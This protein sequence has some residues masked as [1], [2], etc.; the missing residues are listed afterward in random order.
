MR[1][2]T[3]QGRTLGL[4][5][6]LAALVLLAAGVAGHAS[7]GAALAVGLVVGSANGFLFHTTLEHR[8]PILVTSFLRLTML[9]LIAVAL[10]TLT[11]MPLLPLVIGIALSQ[12]LMS[13]VGVREGL[14]S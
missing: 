11:K 6:S 9:T 12:L 14:R 1:A 3:V 13:G 5:L 4:A 8:A 2:S 7:E 10:A